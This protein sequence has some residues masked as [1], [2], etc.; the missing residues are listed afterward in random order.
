MTADNIN[1]LIIKKLI[2]KENGIAKYEPVTDDS[3]SVQFEN[4]V[5]ILAITDTLPEAGT[6]RLNVEYSFNG[7]RFAASQHTFFV[8][9]S[10]H[11]H[12]VNW[13]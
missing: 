9:Y 5:V 4:G 3:I 2:Q 6:Y 8:N 13:G 10:G 1:F 12:A 11:A 7:L